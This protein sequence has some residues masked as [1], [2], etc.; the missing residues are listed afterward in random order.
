MWKMKTYW[1]DEAIDIFGY[2]NNCVIMGVCLDVPD[3]SINCFVIL[4]N[5]HFALALMIIRV[6]YK[7][8]DSLNKIIWMNA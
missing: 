7:N 5:F 6:I 3:F 1:N 4:I 2:N 8:I